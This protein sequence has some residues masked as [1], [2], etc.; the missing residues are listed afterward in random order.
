MTTVTKDCFGA[1]PDGQEVILSIMIFPLIKDILLIKMASSQVSRFTLARGK[2]ELS[3]ISW[4][5]TI[6][7]LK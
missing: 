7:A 2:V 6:T 4:G 3:V 1:S 5:A